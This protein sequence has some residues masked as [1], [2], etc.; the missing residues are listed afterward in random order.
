MR[1]SHISDDVCCQQACSGSLR[2][3]HSCAAFDWPIDAATGLCARIHAYILFLFRFET[4]LPH[5]IV[6]AD[7]ELRE[8][9]KQEALAA[10]RYPMDDLELLS[11]ELTAAATAALADAAS[12]ADTA[13]KLPAMLLPADQ[14]DLACLSSAE[15]LDEAA[16]QHMSRVLYVADTL[17]QFSK[18]FGLKGCSMAELQA[19]L[20]AV[21]AGAAVGGA[22]G[23]GGD[24]KVVREALAWLACTYQGLLKVCCALAQVC[25]VGCG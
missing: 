9:R 3:L 25:P 8:K 10:K 13:E 24:A 12:D 18:Q 1:E 21:A 23:D 11:E 2:R 6:Q 7:K 22:M 15:H 4:K 14:T 17:S 5:I 20:D 19:T 16:S